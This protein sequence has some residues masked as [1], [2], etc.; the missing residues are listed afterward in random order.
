MA[1]KEVE[2]IPEKMGAARAE[3]PRDSQCKK[4]PTSEGET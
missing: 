1:G 3:T 2:S 4:N